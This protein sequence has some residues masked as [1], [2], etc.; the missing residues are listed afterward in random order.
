MAA[1]RQ[2]PLAQRAWWRCSRGRSSSR[3]SLRRLKGRVGR[4]F[5]TSRIRA[6]DVPAATVTSQRSPCGRGPR[7]IAKMVGPAQPWIEVAITNNKQGHVNDAMECVGARRQKMGPW[8]H[9]QLMLGPGRGADYGSCPT[10]LRQLEFWTA[11]APGPAGANRLQH[12][13]TV[14]PKIVRIADFCEMRP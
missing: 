2:A 1:W 12:N 8:P 5:A 4:G 14:W 11:M 7:N 9:V 13:P 10:S 3:Q 6:E